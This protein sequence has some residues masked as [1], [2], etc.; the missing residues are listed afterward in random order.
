MS[1]V[2]TTSNLDNN[3]R[4]DLLIFDF[5]DGYP[6]GSINL[7]FGK[8]PKRI[9]G[10][11]KV[12]QVV[13][14]TLMTRTTSDVLYPTRGTKFAEFTGSYNIQTVDNSEALS[15]ITTAISNAES[16]AKSILNVPTEGLTSQ[17]DS[18]RLIK[19]E[20][21]E[22][23]TTVQMHIIT[24]AGETAPIALPFTS[25]GIEVNS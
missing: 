3:S 7:G 10:V 6:A 25:L 1:R 5:P 22:D 13:L 9:T 20:Q 8:T 21:I 15:L 11:E 23:S 16:Q 18:I 4:Y 17:L 24:R 14:K 2:G 12:V 19:L